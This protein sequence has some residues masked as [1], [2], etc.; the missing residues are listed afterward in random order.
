LELDIPES[1]ELSPE[2]LEAFSRIVREAITNAGHHAGATT[3]RV[4]LDDDDPQALEVADDGRGFDADAET[5]GFGLTSMRERAAAVGASF[6]V[7]SDASGTKVRV[8][9]A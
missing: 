6:T 3:V 4:S 9:L 1:L 2:V 5:S 7:E 8:E